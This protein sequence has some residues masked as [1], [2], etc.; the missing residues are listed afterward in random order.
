MTYKDFFKEYNMSQIPV[1][2]QPSISGQSGTYASPDVTQNPGSFPADSSNVNI[3]QPTDADIKS[4]IDPEQYKKDVEDVKYKVSPDDIRQGMEYELKKQIY[5]NKM[6]AKET[7]VQNLKEN[8][9]YYRDLGMMG[10]T[11]DMMN[12][13]YTPLLLEEE[14]LNEKLDLHRRDDT[15]VVVSTLEN[16]RE[17]GNETY[18]NKDA[19]KGNGFRWDPAITAWTIGLDKFGIATSVIRYINSGYKWDVR[20]NT[21][22]EPTGGDSKLEDLIQKVEDLPEFVAADSSISRNQELAIKIENFIKELANAVQG[23]LTG[24]KVAEYLDF[25]KRFRKYSFNNGILIFIQRPNA[26]FVAGFSAWKKMGVSVNKGAKAIWIYAPMKKKEEDLKPNDDGTEGKEITTSTRMFFRAVPVFDIA[27]TNAAEKG[28]K[29][30]TP[31][32]HDPNTPSETA[33][34]IYEYVLEFCKDKGIKVTHEAAKGGE[35]GWASGDHINL[36]SNVSGLNRLSVLIH[37][38]AHS[39]LHFKDSSVFF[40]DQNP[41]KRTYEQGELQ[42]EAVAYTV[43]RHY[44]LDVKHSAT[45]MALWRADKDAVI[46]SMTIISKASNFIIDGIDTIAKEKQQQEQPPMNENQKEKIGQIIRD[47][48]NQSRNRERVEQKYGN[49]EAI[50]KLMEEKW[51]EKKKRRN[52]NG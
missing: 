42:A 5:K 16:P 51:E 40:G 23:E 29:P 11:P 21:W 36:T 31:E 7:V 10:M 30:E 3:V 26:T 8:P 43:L 38:I 47:M 33:D 22:I 19:L 18:R 13:S 24:S 34:K 41:E 35:M 1:G 50:K 14:D 32:W 27:D 52:Y 15:I 20:K 44:D 25:K 49:F 45:Y 9:R 28:I 4:K 46:K 17:A 37:E 39:L 48:S 2:G 12:E 6:V